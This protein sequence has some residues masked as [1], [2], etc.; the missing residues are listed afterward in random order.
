MSAVDAMV[1]E[2]DRASCWIE[3]KMWSEMKWFI[4]ENVD[5]TREPSLSLAFQWHRTELERLICFII[6]RCAVHLSDVQ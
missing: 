6:V 1:G 4:W 5:K 3:C 2:R